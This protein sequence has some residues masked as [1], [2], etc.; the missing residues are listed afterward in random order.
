M[1]PDVNGSLT[2]E[3]S[4]TVTSLKIKQNEM[5]YNVHGMTI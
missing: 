1:Q 2:P 3:M 4:Q 5:Q